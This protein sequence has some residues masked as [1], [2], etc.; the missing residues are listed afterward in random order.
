MIFLLGHPSYLV[1]LRLYN[2]FILF[3]RFEIR[4]TVTASRY[5]EFREVV[6]A[7]RR[8]K[9]SILEGRRVHALKQ[10]RSPSWAEG[11]VVVGHPRER[12]FLR[13]I[14]IVRKK[15]RVHTS[16]ETRD[17]LSV[18]AQYN[19][20]WGVIPR[21]RDNTTAVVGDIVMIVLRVSSRLLALHMAGIIKARVTLETKFVNCVASLDI[22]RF[23]PTLSQGDSSA[24]GTA[25][26]Y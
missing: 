5:T 6:E 3:F 7:A 24:G 13:V 1:L 26:W 16:G 10:K 15:V 8:V 17:R 14:L 25:S 11:G 21:I 22:R 9:H 23:C 20:Q 18:I 19:H 12:E 4:T 2:F